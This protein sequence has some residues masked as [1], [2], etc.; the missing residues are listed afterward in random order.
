MAVST[1]K[2]T[3]S[4]SSEPSTSQVGV[5]VSVPDVSVDADVKQITTT[6]TTSTTTKDKPTDYK[7][8][9]LSVEEGAIDKTKKDRLAA[10]AIAHYLIQQN[11]NDILAGNWEMASANVIKA[12]LQIKDPVVQ[13]EVARIFQSLLADYQ[14]SFQPAA[15]E[16]TT[17]DSLTT[18]VLS[19][20][21]SITAPKVSVDADV[22]IEGDLT[23]S[24]SVTSTTTVTLDETDAG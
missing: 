9:S 10:S 8:T 7:A 15:K 3:T 16:T 18:T 2:T 1:S 4:T 13:L 5:S 6:K 14:E 12:T 23:V 11:M 24:S 19:E 20:K 22:S 17:V 21:D